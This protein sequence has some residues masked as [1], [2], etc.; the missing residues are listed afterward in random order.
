MRPAMTLSS[1]A[2]RPS[3]HLLQRP[4]HQL[5]RIRAR[6][7]GARKRV[8]RLFA[9]SLPYSDFV[10]EMQRYEA[11]LAPRRT[12]DPQFILDSLFE[13]GVCFV[14]NFLPPEAL[15]RL[16][17]EVLAVAREV[18]A[19]TFK[20]QNRHVVYPQYGFLR[21]NNPE[22]VT[23]GAAQFF[24]DPRISNVVE[25]YLAG[26]GRRME[27]YIDYKFDNRPDANLLPHTDN[28][29]RMVKVF[30]YLNDIPDT[31]APLTY[32]KKSHLKRPWRKIPDYLH[33]AEHPY[34]RFG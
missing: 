26:H 23:P 20:E 17:D 19:G 5:P 2:R 33:Y 31:H 1:V 15:T 25:A 32:W 18:R 8:D 16:H 29:Y 24:D 11:T 7:I 27:K 9:P 3:R 10:A 28:I 14:P 6:E 21:L 34:G 22:N 4:S 30:L 13:D 12:A